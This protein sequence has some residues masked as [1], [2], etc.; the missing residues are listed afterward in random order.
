MVATLE[1]RHGAAGGVVDLF[2]RCIAA[3]PTRSARVAAFVGSARFT[4]IK[5][6][7]P[8]LLRQLM[9]QGIR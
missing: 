7:V 5:E 4:R 2:L 3:P 8:S 1:H 6:E 9:L